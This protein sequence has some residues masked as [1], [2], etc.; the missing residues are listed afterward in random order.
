MN[1][2][3]KKMSEFTKEFEYLFEKVLK[4]WTGNVR[5]FQ[6]AESLVNKYFPYSNE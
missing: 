2:L 1:I 6:V 5:I 3:Y 4:N